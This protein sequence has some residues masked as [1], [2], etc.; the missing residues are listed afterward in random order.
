MLH[1]SWK[2]KLDKATSERCAENLNLSPRISNALIGAD[3]FKKRAIQELQ[4]F[5][6]IP[7]DEKLLENGNQISAVIKVIESLSA[8]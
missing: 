7:I 1:E 4:R 5:I 3:E 6:L 8:E 2:N